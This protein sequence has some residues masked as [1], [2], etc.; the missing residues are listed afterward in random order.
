[1]TAGLLVAC[2]VATP[3]NRVVA[4]QHSAYEELQTFSQVVNYIFHNYPDSVAYSM[5]VRSAI[6]GVLRDLDPH[7]LFYSRIDWERLDSLQKG[8]LAVIGASI[9]AVEGSPT[10]LGVY[11]KSPADRAGI[12]PG[13][14]VLAL[15]DTVV[16]GLDLETVRLRL[17]GADGTKIRVHF[18]RGPRLEPDT[19]T[20][21]LKR[22]F[23][24]SH[25]VFVSRMVDSTTG[26]VRLDEFGE[27]SADEVHDAVS[28]LRKQ[29]AKRLIL[30]LRNNPGGIVV[31]AVDL[32]S[33]FMPKGT[34]VFSTRGRKLD[35]DTTYSTSKDGV[36]RDLPLIVL[37]NGNSAS[38]AEAT[39]A[40][41]Q[42]HDRALLVGR[43]TF[44]KALMQTNFFLSSG[45][46]LHM[47]IGH[48]IAPS[49]R[50]IQRRY[51]GLAVEQYYALAGKSGAAQDTS[52]VYHTDAGRPVRGGGGVMPD[53]LDS[54]SAPLPAWWT[55]ALDSGMV[56]VVADSAAQTVPATPAGLAAFS[57]AP[58]DW[59]GKLLPSVIDR[60]RSRFHIA[61]AA[62]SAQRR[63]M[64]IELAVWVIDERWG[65]E[66][67][68]DFELHHDPDVATALASFS[69]L[70]DLL[71]EAGK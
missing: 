69:R 29:G 36:F 7:S 53:V 66:A 43:R 3:G 62:D 20:V 27:K 64:A 26:F 44:G 52:H 49:G 5:L 32:V 42:D 48:V 25:Y 37:V 54:A 28:H 39:A 22:K 30:D 65:A 57:T 40:S 45:E 24:Q 46:V 2:L 58:G 11:P 15:N 31:E 19:F 4:Q 56:P 67:L 38:A 63:R 51:S 61:A 14:R 17:A 60:V 23:L 13:D 6:D 70:P 71:K 47:T 8:E 33:E 35:V 12:R 18:A 55:A 10:V 21:T 16:A 68:M 34:V 41:L 9:D 50:V 59:E 1:M